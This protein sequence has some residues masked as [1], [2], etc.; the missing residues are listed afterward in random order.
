MTLHSVTAAAA[1]DLS[2]LPEQTS[3]TGGLGAAG[4]PVKPHTQFYATVLYITCMDTL[5]CNYY[6]GK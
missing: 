1:T 2:H 3:V 6:L 5:N 4:L